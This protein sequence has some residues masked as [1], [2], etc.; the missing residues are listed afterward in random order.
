MMS[1]AILMSM[2]AE[3]STKPP[4]AE[5]VDKLEGPTFAQ[6]LDARVGIPSESV[7]KDPAAGAPPELR[8]TKAEA[9]AGTN[10]WNL[11]ASPGGSAALAEK[12]FV[13][14]TLPEG[15]I[16]KSELPTKNL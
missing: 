9:T 10:A 14:G 2:G 13:A 8:S 5:K 7:G 12:G 16:P 1:T 6:T 4:V 11:E 3:Q 15:S